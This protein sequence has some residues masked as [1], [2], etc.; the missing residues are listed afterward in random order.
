VHHV[1]HRLTILTL[2]AHLLYELLSY[3]LSEELLLV[4][5]IAPFG[6]KISDA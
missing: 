1:A 6:A 3:L 5:S 4:L 2:T